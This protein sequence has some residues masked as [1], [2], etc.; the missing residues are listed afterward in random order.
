MLLPT[1]F[2]V[3]RHAFQE[4]RKIACALQHLS[5]LYIMRGIGKSVSRSVIPHDAAQKNPFG[6]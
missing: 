6:R 3:N 4:L 2:A 5:G 1:F